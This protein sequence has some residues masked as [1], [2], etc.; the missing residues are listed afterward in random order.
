MKRTITSLLGRVGTTALLATALAIS[1][2]ATAIVGSGTA[3]AAPQPPTTAYV[4][5]Q[6]CRLVDTRRAFGAVAIDPLT[7]NVPTR[8]LCGIPA[9]A[10]A[11]ALTL[12]A[13]QPSAGGYLTAWPGDQARPGVSNI[14]F[15][16]HQV[17]A[18]G[19]IVPLDA[20]GGFDVYTS[21]PAQVVVDVVGA[22]VPATSAKSG[23]FVPQPPTRLFDSRSSGKVPP[24]GTVD[25]PIPAGVPTDA[26]AMSVNITVT[27]AT[28]P[29][30][31]TAF[32]VGS[33]LPDA[34][35]L[36]LDGSGQTRA[37][38]GILPV[39]PGGLALYSS[40]GG[41]VIVDLLG[42]FTGPSAAS[43]TDGLFT[44]VQPSRLLDTRDTSSLGSGVPLYPGGGLELGTSH[45]GSMA[46]NLTSVDGDPGYIT[47]YAAGT[48]LPST[49]TVNPT[50]GGD[51]VANF[52]ITQVSN[53]GLGVFSQSQ[54]HVLVDLQGWFSGP[55]A[56]ATQPAPGNAPPPTPVTTYTTC[57]NGG[58][59]PLDQFNAKRAA[60]HVA[61]L[62]TSASAQDFA[63]AYAMRLATAGN[64][65][66]H[67][68]D[69]ERNAA[70]GC[71]SGENIADATGTSVQT[72]LDLWFAS[73]PHFANI[74]STMWHSVGVGFVTRT[75]P[76]SEPVTWAVTDFGAC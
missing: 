11:L 60:A 18:N 50:G 10:S 41:H 70:L 25:V 64:G 32:P 22:F 51:V 27:D 75:D 62:V 7:L 58:S 13:V 19:A 54:S 3:G 38:A 29:G 52:A 55:T 33:P 40:G 43:G 34:S 2:A 47:S 72:I 71:S 16:V 31:V 17:R 14:N 74:K 24:G 57:S 63:C 23:R 42:Y 21:V 36:D 5:L 59:A 61:P 8:G 6:P 68:T 53:R 49:S 45:G 9:G 69:A 1:A 39:S 56:N 15:G 67:S 48:P 37:A 35:T 76:G 4:A 20:N 73:A 12:T 66:V 30:F 44:P 65:L 28:G 46:Y 26:S